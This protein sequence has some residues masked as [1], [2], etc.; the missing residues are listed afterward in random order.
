M[1]PNGG[2]RFTEFTC[3]CSYIDKLLIFEDIAYL[4]TNQTK[5]PNVKQTFTMLIIE[6][7]E[8]WGIILRSRSR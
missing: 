2:H 4:K 6:T 7:L 3:F 8:S 5:Y 1:S